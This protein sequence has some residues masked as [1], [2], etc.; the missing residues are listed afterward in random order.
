MEI[1]RRGERLSIEPRARNRRDIAYVAH[2]WPRAV[3]RLFAL[4]GGKNVYLDSEF[5]RLLSDV[6]MAGQH[7][8]LSWDVAGTIYGRVMFGLPPGRTCSSKNTQVTKIAY[9]PSAIPAWRC[10]RLQFNPAMTA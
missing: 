10:A 8:S 5:Q 6:H 1:V 7:I 9:S 3:D 2:Q 4:A